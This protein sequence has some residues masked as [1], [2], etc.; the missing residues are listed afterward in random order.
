MNDIEREIEKLKMRKLELANK[1]S[2]T[3]DVDERE[4]LQLEIDRL[5]AQID[6]LERFRKKQSSPAG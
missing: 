6:T 2:V 1:M 5:Q 3:I 4:E